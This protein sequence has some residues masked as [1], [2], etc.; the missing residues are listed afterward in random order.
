MGPTILKSATTCAL[1][2]IYH[3]GPASPSF[4]HSELARAHASFSVCRAATNPNRPSSRV[5]FHLAVVL[6]PPHPPA[7]PT[8][9]PLHHRRAWPTHVHA[10]HPPRAICVLSW[11]PCLRRCRRHQ[12]FFATPTRRHLC[13]L[14]QPRAPLLRFG[15]LL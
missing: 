2:P 14:Q 10:P 1:S 3:L 7:M 5:A 13:H 15:A 4:S 11:S 12:I 9:S 6:A 8:L